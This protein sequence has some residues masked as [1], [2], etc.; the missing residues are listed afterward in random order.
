MLKYTPY[1]LFYWIIPGLIVFFYILNVGIV[2]FSFFGNKYVFTS[3][4]SRADCHNKLIYTM[5][6]TYQESRLRG[7]DAEPEQIHGDFDVAIEE[8][9]IKVHENTDKTDRFSGFV[10]GTLWDLTLIPIYY[11]IY[12]VFNGKLL[13]HNRGTKITGS[14]RLQVLV[15]IGLA[16]FSGIW[17]LFYEHLDYQ[18]PADVGF[19]IFYFFMLPV[20]GI[21]N[22]LTLILFFI[23]KRKQQRI[24]DFIRIVLQAQPSM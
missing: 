13:V 1:G 6:E 4:L 5:K 12:P 7:E 8:N 2:I 22:V 20:F 24:L 16:I 23:G 19:G 11:A 14:F 18:G 15:I 10:T 21:I 9:N 3:Q 17:F